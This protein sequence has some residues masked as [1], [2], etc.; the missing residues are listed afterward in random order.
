VRQRHPK[1]RGVKDRC[2]FGVVA[3][4]E[5]LYGVVEP[6]VRKIM[7]VSDCARGGEYC[8]FGLE[9]AVHVAGGAADVIRKCYCGAAHEE[10]LTS[11]SPALKIL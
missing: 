6:V 2:R 5:T 4:K 8:V 3:V 7:S 1:A 10:H 9:Y 11:N